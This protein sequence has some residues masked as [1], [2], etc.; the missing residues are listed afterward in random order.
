MQHPHRHS[1]KELAGKLRQALEAFDNRRVAFAE[2][3]HVA[4]DIEE[5]NLDGEEEY[6]D[7]IYECLQL[8]LESPEVSFRLPSPPKSTKHELTKNL[9]MWAFEVQHEAYPFK[10]YFKFCLKEQRDGTLYCHIDCHE[11]RPKNT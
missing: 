3:T 11:S 5:L 6:L 7:L 4:A 10:L 8:A 2:P 9:P 1:H